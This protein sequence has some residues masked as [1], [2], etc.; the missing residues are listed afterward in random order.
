MSDRSDADILEW[1][2]RQA[3][4]L[5]RLAAGERGVNDQVDWGNVIEEVESAGRGQLSAVRS[6][7]SRRSSMT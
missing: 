6:H 7:T 5:R 2:E 1:S 4:L 3:A